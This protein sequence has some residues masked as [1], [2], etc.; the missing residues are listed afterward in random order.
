MQAKYQALGITPKKMIDDSSIQLARYISDVEG[1]SPF[2]RSKEPTDIV[3][4]RLIVPQEP[5]WRTIG[6]N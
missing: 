6:I 1:Q 5:F 4:L 3:E 2:K